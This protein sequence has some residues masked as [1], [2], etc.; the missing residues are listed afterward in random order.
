METSERSFA[1]DEPSFE[2]YSYDKEAPSKLLKVGQVFGHKEIKKG[3]IFLSDYVCDSRTAKVLCIIG[4][5][6]FI[7]VD[8]HAVLERHIVG[9]TMTRITSFNHWTPNKVENFS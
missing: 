3:L 8:K 9:D 5:D 6:Y 1:K 4:F 2:E 7:A